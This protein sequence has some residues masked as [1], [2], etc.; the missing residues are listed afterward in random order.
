MTTLVPSFLIGTINV[1]N[2]A[3][4]LAP[5][6]LIKTSSLLQEK[7]TWIKA[8]LSSNFNR[9][10]PLTTELPAIECLKYQCI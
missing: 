3:N 1:Y 6:F 8:C 5:S 7:R 2:V 10:P 4:T 9:I